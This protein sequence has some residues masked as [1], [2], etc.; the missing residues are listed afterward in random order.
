MRNRLTEALNSPKSQ[1]ADYLEI[2]L[3]NYESTHIRFQGKD[4]EKI[5][6]SQE[7]GGNVRALVKGKWGFV[8]FNGWDDLKNKTKQAIEIATLIGNQTSYLTETEPAVEY[9]QAECGR[10]FRKISLKEKAAMMKQ[11]SNIMINCNAKIQSSIVNYADRY[12]TVYFAN[13]EGTYIQHE[14]PYLSIHFT[15]IARNGDDVQ[16]AQESTG[17]IKGY[18]SAEQLSPI[19]QK[20]AQRA[21]NLLKAS[22]VQGGEYTV[23]LDPILAGVFIHEAFGHL[24]EADFLYEDPRMQSLMKL[25]KKVGTP[26]LNVVDDG[27]LPGLL[28]SSKYDDE[29]VLTRKNYLI[30]EGILSGRLHSRETSARMGEQLTGNARA[31][32]Y[33]FK[34]I[35]RMTN[36]YIEQGK[37]PYRDLFND[38]KKGIYARQFYGGNTT[39]EMYT[40]SA[41]EGY[42][43]ENGRITKPIRDITLTGNL[44]DTLHNIDGIGN[45]LKIVESG[46]GCGKGGQQPLPVTFGSPHIRIQKVIVG[47]S[48]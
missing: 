22:S 8:T 34:P 2:R 42:M 13:S 20:T 6:S 29:G 46:G 4:M 21:V 19:A 7:M 31:I 16:I 5:S 9:L 3:E 47:G 40:F 1:K 30:K 35:V 32:S 11:Y 43:I 48:H 27:S 39:F 18:D 28:G 44:F 45:D 17:S 36:T 25:G 10:D 15:A 33:H 26:E 41:G 23:I 12:T 14:R 38:I 37:T 24:S